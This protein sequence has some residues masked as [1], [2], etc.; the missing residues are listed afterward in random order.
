MAVESAA[1][2]LAFL[3]ADEFGATATI[4]GTSVSGILDTESA[5]IDF[6]DGLV[7]HVAAMPRF[8]CR[9]ADVSGVAQGD[10]VTISGTTYTVADIR[11][12]GTGMT[13]LHLSEAT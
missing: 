13:V 11:A 6:G 10:E 7:D 3:S 2:R 5:E 9:S 12:D 8:E 1:D 4:G